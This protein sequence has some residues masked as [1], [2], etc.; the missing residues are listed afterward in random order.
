MFYFCY[1]YINPGN[2]LILSY[3]ANFKKDC[4]IMAT[5][6]MSESV[7][8]HLLKCSY[9][10]CYYN[11]NLMASKFSQVEMSAKVQNRSYLV[12]LWISISREDCW[13][14]LGRYKCKSQNYWEDQS[15][16]SYH[17]LYLLYTLFTISCNDS[18]YIW[19]KH[20]GV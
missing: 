16:T 11:Q 13:E 15:C 6:L 1:G 2:S 14:F 5:I 9:S 20:K 19:N 8:L 4:G 17:N 7:K 12:K 3:L 18:K 10:E